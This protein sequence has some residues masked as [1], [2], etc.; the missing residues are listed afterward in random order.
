MVYRQTAWEKRE[1]DGFIYTLFW[2]S[3][4]QQLGEVAAIGRDLL[5]NFPIEYLVF[6][7]LGGIKK[8]RQ[9]IYDLT[10]LGLYLSPQGRSFIILLKISKVAYFVFQEGLDCY[11][12]W[13]RAQTT[14]KKPMLENL[15]HLLARGVHLYGNT[16]QLY[17]EVTLQK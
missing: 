5:D 17:T 3:G 14:I 9:F 4:Y 10:Y 1:W 12:S 13:D 6:K 15:I 16:L 7:Y 8:I 11:F 2:F